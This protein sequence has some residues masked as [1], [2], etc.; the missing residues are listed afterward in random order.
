MLNQAEIMD[1]L[2]SLA[3]SFDVHYINQKWGSAK[4][5]YDTAVTVATFCDISQQ[6]KEKLFGNRP[7]KDDDEPFVDGLFAEEKVDW[8]Y[9]ECAVKGNQTSRSRNS[10]RLLA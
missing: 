2:Y 1:K 5:C 9:K 6:E 8:V 10:R 4:W 7:Y 3:I